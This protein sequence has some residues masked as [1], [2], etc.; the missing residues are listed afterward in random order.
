MDELTENA[1]KKSRSSKTAK[2]KSTRK[3]GGSKGQPTIREISIGDVALRAYYLWQAKGC[4]PSQAL[5]NWIEAEA[6][7]KQELL[8]EKD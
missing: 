8:D 7:F 5:E 6:Q 2:T 3:S 1:G 4:P